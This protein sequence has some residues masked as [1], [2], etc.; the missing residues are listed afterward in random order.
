M[1]KVHKFNSTKDNVEAARWGRF[2]NSRALEAWQWFR[3]CRH[4]ESMK[5]SGEQAARLDALKAIESA[6]KKGDTA[7]FHDLAELF[8]FI[9][10]EKAHDAHRMEMGCYIRRQQRAAEEGKRKAEIL[11]DE[12]WLHLANKFPDEISERNFARMVKDFGVKLKPK[13]TGPRRK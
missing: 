7:F 11:R 8:D 13:K 4:P 9:A 5:A 3:I 12:V 2:F 1:N 6:M 10:K